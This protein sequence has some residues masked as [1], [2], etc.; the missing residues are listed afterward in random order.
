MSFAISEE[1]IIAE[2]LDDAPRRLA[3]LEEEVAS[4]QN[5]NPR[6]AVGRELLYL[7]RLVVKLSSSQ[8]RQFAS[9]RALLA[10]GVAA[11]R[12]RVD[13]LLPEPAEQ[14]PAVPANTTTSAGTSTSSTGSTSHF[15]SFLR[16]SRGAHNDEDG[17]RLLA[18][19]GQLAAEITKFPVLSLPSMQ[20]SLVMREWSGEDDEI[21]DFAQ[22]RRR[23]AVILSLEQQADNLREIQSMVAAQ[24]EQQQPVID[25]IEIDVS[26]AAAST[27]EAVAVLSDCQKDGS[28]F[29]M[30][31][32]ASSILGAGAVSAGFCIGSGVVVSGAALTA[33]FGVES[34]AS[35]FQRSALEWMT[36]HLQRVFAPM[37]PD[38]IQMLRSAGS[39]AERRLIKK[40]GEKESWSA[41]YFSGSGWLMWTL[42]YHRK[43]DLRTGGHAV[44]TSWTVKFQA[45]HV[46][47]VLQRLS[48]TGSLDPCCEV[49]WS[50]PVD[51]V[52][53]TFVRYL[54]FSTNLGWRVCRDFYCVC[55]CHKVVT[56]PEG[57]L[58]PET[59]AAPEDDSPE[60]DKYVFAVCTLE[61]E[62]LERSGLPANNADIQHGAI[63]TCGILVTDIGDGNSRIE[64]MADVDVRSWHSAATSD[65]LVRWHVIRTA[66][67]LHK[68]LLARS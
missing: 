23:K 13:R 18:V 62:L 60:P 1:K 64:I 39:E 37:H 15:A 54:I 10:P 24:V 26:A 44:S 6:S 29:W 66:N 46:F 8:S 59:Q 40:L 58:S 5:W 51:G 61:P 38:D 42:P 2:T 27:G 55:R 47:Q 50:R 43:S 9:K 36:E 19:E 35:R 14:T 48:I 31:F 33:M 30:Y 16:P 32:V 17:V 3:A 49:V 41:N 56:A 67:N 65:H 20:T 22:D 11:V 12:A 52:P 57:S 53:G 45:S 4:L 21:A 34:A 25:Q 68:A 28:L 63:H 7:E